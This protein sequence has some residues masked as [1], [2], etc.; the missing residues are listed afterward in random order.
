[1]PSQRKRADLLLVER[2]L[3]ESRSRAQALILAGQVFS[4]ERR[5]DKAGEVLAADADLRVRGRDHP[6]VSR[7]GVKLDG[8]LTALDICVK[9]RVAADFGASTGGFTDCLLRR[10]AAKVYAIDVGYGQLHP[11]LR[12]HDRVRVMERTNARYL[13]ATHLPERVELVVIDAS[14]ISC[15]KLLP[16]A[17]AILC[18]GGAVLAMV[19]P[20][21]EVGKG[22][23]RRGVVRDDALRAR[24]VADV[25]VRAEELG[26]VHGGQCDS[27]LPG[28]K[29]NREVFVYLR[30]GT[31]DPDACDAG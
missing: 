11:T 9:G 10:G 20:Q 5:V 18:P 30:L 28:P 14:F 12:A 6:F 26:F 8:A 3:A 23:V 31:A 22:E 2:A 4:G 7:G 25:L 16:A 29:G 17:R 15:T 27:T 24:A 19:K 21:F 13:D 1:M